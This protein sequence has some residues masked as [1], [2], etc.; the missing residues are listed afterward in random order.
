M[1][2]WQLLTSDF[3][4][5]LRTDTSKLTSL[6]GPRVTELASE[7]CGDAFETTVGNVYLP[8]NVCTSGWTWTF[9]LLYA[10]IP[11]KDA[12]AF[13]FLNDPDPPKFSTLPPPVPVQT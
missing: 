4:S 11:Y 2:I 6:S 10:V 1:C 13:F 8:Y 12:S 9:R 5:S 7:V 3:P